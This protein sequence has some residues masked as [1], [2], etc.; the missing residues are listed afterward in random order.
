MATR[1]APKKLTPAMWKTAMK[2]KI[3]QHRNALDELERTADQLD[4][5]RRKLYAKG[6]R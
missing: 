3:R 4:E 5:C 2:K 6:K 1:K